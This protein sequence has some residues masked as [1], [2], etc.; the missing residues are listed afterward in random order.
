MRHLRR[1]LDHV[2]LIQIDSVNVLARSQELPLF[3]RLGDHP[4]RLIPDAAEAGELFEYWG[5]EASHIPIDQYPLYRW[6]MDHARAGAMWSGL[7]NLVASKPQLITETM[8]HIRAVGPVVAS[9]LSTRTGPKGA[10]WDWDDAKAALEYLFWVGDL[11]ARRR[12]TDFARIYDLPE[13]VIPAIHL[14]AP[15]PTEADARKALLVRAARALGVATLKDLA[16]YHRQRVPAVKHLLH[17]LVED[18]QL[19]PVRVEGWRSPAYLHPLVRRPKAIHARALLSPFDSLV[20]HRDRNERMFDFHYRIEIY[21]PQ[22]QRRFGYYVLP[23]L[24]DE[25]IVARVDLK[26]DRANGC[27]LVPGAFSEAH[28]ADDRRDMARVADCLA[29]EVMLMAQWLGLPR[30]E[31][32]S[33]GDLAAPLVRALRQRRTTAQ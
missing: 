17:E 18:A 3:A 33:R 19:I 7:R 11:T 20:W 22:A 9:D 4:R 25:R 13:R 15:V 26:A 31:V 23:F 24:L 10:W 32:G 14:D 5:H 27:L 21:T 8:A 1:V 30:V 12:P 6:K 2:G 29:D 28:V 16:D